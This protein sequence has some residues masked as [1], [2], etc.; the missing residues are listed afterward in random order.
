MLNA[1]ENMIV[2]DYKKAFR[3]YY[4]NK[5]DGVI[6]LDEKLNIKLDF[7]HFRIEDSLP[8]LNYTIFP[9]RS[10][11]LIIIYVTKGEGKRIIGKFKVQVTDNTFMII[12]S[13]MINSGIYNHDTQGFFLSLNLKFFL[14][15][16]FPKHY[17]VKF[18]IFSNG[19]IPYVHTDFKQGKYLAE[20][21]ETILDESSHSRKGKEEMLALKILELII[22]FER[23]LKVE[24]NNQKDIVSPLVIKYIQL[25]NEHYKIHHNTSYYAEKLHVH[26]NQLN[27]NTKRYLGQVAKATID[28]MLVKESEQLL[29]QTTLSVK[30]LAYELGFQSTSHFSRF[31]KRHKGISP[32]GYRNQAFENVA[33]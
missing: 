9:S 30:E 5:N 20:I 17:L 21:F 14:Q 29:H 3:E 2:Q 18:K 10:S 6:N 25:I 33:N 1:E 15:E 7:V 23:L 12:P 31:F 8:E 28:S 11:R 16:H 26:P 19:F 22:L 27:A 4:N 32:A 24:N 13:E